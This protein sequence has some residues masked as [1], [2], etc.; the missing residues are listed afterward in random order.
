LFAETTVTPPFKSNSPSSLLQESQAGTIFSPETF[1]FI[2]CA[3]KVAELL[4]PSIEHVLGQDL[5]ELLIQ[6]CFHEPQLQLLPEVPFLFFQ[7]T[8]Y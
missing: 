8:N 2:I 1:E 7:L 4:H 3:P 5:P 6:C